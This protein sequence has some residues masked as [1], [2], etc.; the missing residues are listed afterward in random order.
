MKPSSAKNK[1]RKAQQKIKDAILEA[2]PELTSDDVSSRSMGAQGTDILLS[3]A[4][5]KLFP[6]AVES[7]HLARIAVYKLF[8]QA[9]ANAGDEIP[10]LVIKQ[11]NSPPLAVLD[12]Q[13]FLK[14]CKS[15]KSS[16][17]KTAQSRSKAP[18]KAKS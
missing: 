3:T 8:K 5:K 1:G 6:Y 11:N 16:K 7:K 17:P 10:L 12:F 13:E 4:A 15:N 14:L 9:Q 18:S 2:F